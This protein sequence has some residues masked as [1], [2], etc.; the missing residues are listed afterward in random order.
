MRF[1][2]QPH[3]PAHTALCTC[4][5]APETPC[6]GLIHSAYQTC[7][8]LVHTHTSWPTPLSKLSPAGRP[9][10]HT[11]TDLGQAH[12]CNHSLSCASRPAVQPP[13]L[14]LSPACCRP[15]RYP[16]AGLGQTKRAREREGGEKKG[17]NGTFSAVEGHLEQQARN[18]PLPAEPTKPVRRKILLAKQPPPPWRAN[19]PLS[20]GA[21]RA[22]K[23]WEGT[24]RRG[25]S[26]PLRRGHPGTDSARGRRRAKRPKMK[27]QDNGRRVGFCQW[28]VSAF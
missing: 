24:E 15:P 7:T 21:A 6:Y 11:C 5:A 14:P 10:G 23:H 16:H 1:T 12:H 22:R 26:G 3:V 9:T 13:L 8:L 19:K 25:Q 4:H 27:M 18:S 2:H 28:Y 17:K 20:C